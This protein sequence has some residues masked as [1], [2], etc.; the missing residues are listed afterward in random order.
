MAKCILKTEDEAREAPMRRKCNER[1]Q[2]GGKRSLQCTSTESCSGRGSVSLVCERDV[3]ASRGRGW[4]AARPD[5]GVADKIK[6]NAI[7]R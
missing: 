4:G 3:R 1:W 5:Q 7:R 6:P 2:M